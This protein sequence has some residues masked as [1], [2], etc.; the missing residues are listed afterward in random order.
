MNLVWQRQN[1]IKISKT[2]HQFSRG[3]SE[4]S[5]T[6]SDHFLPSQQ[7][8]TV[9]HIRIYFYAMPWL[10]WIFANVRVVFAG[11]NTYSHSPKSISCNNGEGRRKQINKW[12]KEWI[13]KWYKMMMNSSIFP[14]FPHI[15]RFNSPLLS[16]SF[17]H[18]IHI[19]ISRFLYCSFHLSS[20]SW[21]MF[22]FAFSVNHDKS[23]FSWQ[24]CIEKRP[25]ISHLF[26]C[27]RVCGNHA[28]SLALLLPCSSHCF[29]VLLPLNVF[30]P[31]L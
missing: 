15:R 16:L 6:V 31:A 12:M 23:V 22:S 24:A 13:L 27:V 21:W 30:F 19:Y 25:I 2:F 29:A 20:F 9:L 26:V 17:I 28:R 8:L 7:C 11:I 10:N 4:I 14:A 3:K 1:A 18:F 5:S